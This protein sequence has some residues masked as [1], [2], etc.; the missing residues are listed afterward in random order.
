M[1]GLFHPDGL[2]WLWTA[3][4]LS[5]DRVHVHIRLILGGTRCPLFMEDGMLETGLVLQK[6][7]NVD[8]SN[9]IQENELSVG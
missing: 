7:A 9:Q 3:V 8:L 5:L 6:A 2:G 1:G 4:A